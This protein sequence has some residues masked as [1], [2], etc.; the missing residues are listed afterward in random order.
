MKYILQLLSVPFR[1]VPRLLS[2]QTTMLTETIYIKV[3]FSTCINEISGSNP[4]RIIY[5]PEDFPWF[6]SIPPDKSRGSIFITPKP[7]LSLSYSTAHSWTIIIFDTKQPDSLTKKSRSQ[8]KQLLSLVLENKLYHISERSETSLWFEK[9]FK[10][11]FLI[12]SKQWRS[13]ALRP[14]V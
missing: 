3:T 11:Q 1:R 6:F 4:F 13:P 7:L 5:Y 14:N 8:Q 9:Y 2:I 12:H 10:L